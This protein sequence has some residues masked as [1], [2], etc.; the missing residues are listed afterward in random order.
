MKTL[1]ALLILFASASQAE[2]FIQNGFGKIEEK[3]T[4][5]QYGTFTLAG[6]DVQGSLM[7]YPEENKALLQLLAKEGRV[8]FKTDSTMGLEQNGKVILYKRVSKTRVLRF[9]LDGKA[10]N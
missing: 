6:M 10:L 9:V 2:V 7:E 4:I 8:L 3:K 5:H 1:F